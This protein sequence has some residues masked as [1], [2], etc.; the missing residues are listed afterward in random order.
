MKNLTEEKAGRKTRR[1]YTKEFK[2]E[3]VRLS[4]EPGMGAS[5]VARDLGI[6]RSLLCL[7]MK[8]LAETGTDAFRGHGKR[9]ELEQE[10][11]VL[12]QRLRIAEEERDILKKAAIWFAKESE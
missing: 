5:K 4:R 11:A 2:V 10:N 9:T 6:A 7:W 8:A 3:A 12:R 1:Q